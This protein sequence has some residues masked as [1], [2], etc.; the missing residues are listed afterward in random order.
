MKVEFQIDDAVR[1]HEDLIRI[2]RGAADFLADRDTDADSEAVAVWRLGW[3]TDGTPRVTLQ[4]RDQDF[5]HTEQFPP[6]RLAPADRLEYRL[7][8]IWNDVL[9]RRSH[10]G[11]KR[12]NELIA[13][14]ED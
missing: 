10:R 2:V 12:L 5:A 7:V 13:Q 1:D 8:Q 9:E 6:A 3:G 11:L 4:L 14:L